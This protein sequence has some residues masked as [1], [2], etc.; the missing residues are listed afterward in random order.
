[1]SDITGSGWIE[2]HLPAPARP[3]GRLARLDRPIGVWLLLW[4][5]WW[6]LAL[7]QTAGWPDPWL[8]APRI[9][10]THCQGSGC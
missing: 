2:R 9:L 4:P 1:M 10:G 6:G 5:C 3:Y 7:A 8:E